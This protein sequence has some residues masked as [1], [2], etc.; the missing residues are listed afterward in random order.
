M[1]PEEIQDQPTPLLTGVSEV[2]TS[3][4]NSYVTP[5]QGETP[6]RITDEPFQTHVIA[7]AVIGTSLDT[8]TRAIKGAYVFEQMGS[9]AIGEFASGIS[10]QILISPDGIVAT[11]LHGATTF[12][13]DGITGSATFKGTLQAGTVVAGDGSVIIETALSGNGRIVLYNGGIP[14]IVIGDPS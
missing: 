11:D 7:S 13:L 5:S 3:G 12:T 9:L 1:F 6:V 10:G 2:Q 14:S 8:Q 4:S